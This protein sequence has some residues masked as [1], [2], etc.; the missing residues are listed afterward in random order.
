MNSD[1]KYD[2][3]VVGAGPAGSCAAYC[4]AKQGLRVALVDRAVFPR[5][6]LCGGLL[7]ARSKNI[8]TSIHDED[9]DQAIECVSF[10]AKFFHKERL[11][12]SVSDYK[13]IYFTCRS[14]FDAYLLEM[15]EAQ[16]AVVM[17][18]ATVI[19]V[20]P[21]RGSVTLKG[22]QTLDADF[23]IGADGVNGRVARHLYPNSR[24]RANLAFGLE[25]ELPRNR[26]RR[27]VCDP[28]IFF[29]VVNWGYGWIFPKPETL[30]V[31][32]GG[33]LAQNANFKASF[34]TFLQSICGEVPPIVPRGHHIPFGNYLSVPGQ[35]NILLVGDAAGLVEPITGEGI[36]FAMQ[37]GQYAAEAIVEA[38]NLG[39]R[40]DAIRFYQKRYVNIVGMLAAAR[41]LRPLIFSGAMEPLFAKAIERSSSAIRK[42]MDLLA[43]D[44]D[45]PTYTRFLVR[46]VVTGGVRTMLFGWR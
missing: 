4:M 28:Q 39:S 23:I 2:A 32:L 10:G 1:A 20:D 31:G 19:T 29:G 17:Q 22:G 36:G 8:F 44:I 13:P 18:G 6:K 42:Y 46:K 14:K 3:V 33:L 45:Y 41:F 21:D 9:W 7:S 37:S 40:F 11:L 43:G 38:A 30:T 24:T 12:N 16:G 27:E 5:E 15:A 34:S 35:K 26:F 25:V